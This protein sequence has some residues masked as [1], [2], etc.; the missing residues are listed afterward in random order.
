VPL[1]EEGLT[2][3]LHKYG[4]VLP[5]IAVAQAKLESQLGKSNIGREAKNLFGIMHHKCQYV[6]GKYGL[7]ATYNSYEDNIKCYIHI[8]D[9]YL[10]RID[11]VYAE[12]GYSD[13]IRKMK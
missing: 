5:N 8:Q 1:T 10:K 13:L 11:G 3:T 12:P 7:F 9:H 2:A 4:C 6:T